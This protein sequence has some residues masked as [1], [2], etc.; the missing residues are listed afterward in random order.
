MVYGLGSL[1]AESFVMG[2]SSEVGKHVGAYNVS[3]NVVRY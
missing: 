3:E 2:L 1:D